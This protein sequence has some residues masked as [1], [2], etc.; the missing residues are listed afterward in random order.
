MNQRNLHQ[1]N[2]D[3][4]LFCKHGQLPDHSN[5]FM[6]ALRVDHGTDFA[7][8]AAQTEARILMS[9]CVLQGQRA[10]NSTELVS[11]ALA[12]GVFCSRFPYF[13]R[14]MFY[15][16]VWGSSLYQILW[17][18]WQEDGKAANKTFF[19]L[20]CIPVCREI[21][22]ESWRRQ[23]IGKKKKHSGKNE[24]SWREFV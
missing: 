17:F 6:Q 1:W 8:A 13:P 21:L 19:W 15:Q 5:N 18:T 4:W 22:M 24:R 14:V 16:I 11:S 23:E 10:D 12:S 7:W 9:G 3:F 20:S 2:W